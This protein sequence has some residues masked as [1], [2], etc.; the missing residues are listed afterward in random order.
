MEMTFDELYVLFSLVVTTFGL[1]AV[2]ALCYWNKLR[3]MIP[4]AKQAGPS[5][6]GSYAGMCTSK[7]LTPSVPLKQL[8]LD[9]VF[10]VFAE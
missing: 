1:V 2:P 8:T 3:M 9:D 10:K 4:P 5:Y 7:T 6:W